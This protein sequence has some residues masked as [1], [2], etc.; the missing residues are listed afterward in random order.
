MEPDA[1][2]RSLIDPQYSSLTRRVSNCGRFLVSYQARFDIQA[3]VF[4]QTGFELLDRD[5][6]HR[7]VAVIS[8][9]VCNY[10]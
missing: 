10:Q 1:L 2:A 6:S 8:S 4:K 9:S 7:C 3:Q 5:L